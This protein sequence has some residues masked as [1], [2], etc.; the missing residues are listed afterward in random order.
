MAQQKFW[1]KSY[2]KDIPTELDY[3]EFD[4]IVDLFEKS[5][6]THQNHPAFESF[7]KSISYKELD[8]ASFEFAKFLQFQDVKKGDR[9]AIMMPNVLQYPIALAGILRCGAIVVNINPLYT[10]RELEQQLKDS[11]ATTIIIL[12]NFAHVL[13][14]IIKNVPIEQVIVTSLGELLGPKGKLLDFVVKHIKKLVPKWELPHYTT[15]KAALDVGKKV[16]FQKPEIH[17]NDIAFLQYTGGTTGVSKGAILEHRNVIANIL[18]IEAWLQPALDKKP[19]EQLTF[20]CALPLYHIFALTA[21]GLFSVRAGGKTILIAN[22][23]DIPGFIK[24]LKKIKEFH[25]FPAVNTLF[26]ALMQNP[27]FA[28]VDFSS[29]LV[30]IGGGMS[31]QKVVS[32]RWLS[33]TGTPI[34]EGYGLSETSPVACCNLSTIEE[35]TGHVGL[36]LP[37]TEISVRDA[38]GQELAVNESGEICIKGPQ[39]MRGYW[40]R[41]DETALVMTQDGFFKSGDIG[42]LNDDGF[43][44][45]I[46]RKKDMIIV[47]GFNVYPNEIEEVLS[48]MPQILES[49]VVGVDDEHSGSSVKAF[50]VKKDESLTEELIFEHCAKNLTNYKRPKHIQFVSSLPKSNVGKILRKEL[51]EN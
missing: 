29:L 17:Q 13:C 4:S 31:V 16:G 21:C 43:L 22:P 5:F 8:E 32:D 40:N 47:S 51:R 38:N 20:I 28:K 36:P 41:D 24:T 18:Q 19:I 34:V 11:G 10:A 33:I 12:E 37:N 23:K 26:N 15:F 3:S 35:F 1:L 25:I 46:D 49:A 30:S 45:L 9:V 39:V 2:P 48:Q 7:G 27:E 50:I 42:F 6:Q 14:S 44:K